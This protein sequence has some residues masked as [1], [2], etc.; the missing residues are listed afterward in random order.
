MIRPMITKI[1][2]IVRG[3]FNYMTLRN[4]RQMLK[5]LRKCWK[6]ENNYRGI[7]NLCGCVLRAKASE[8]EE[9]CPEGKW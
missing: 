5:R 3:W 6:C 9:S 4:R 7:C 2:H 1:K 8:P